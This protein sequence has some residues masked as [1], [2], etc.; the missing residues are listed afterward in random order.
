MTELVKSTFLCAQAEDQALLYAIVFIES[1]AMALD[2]LLSYHVM[3]K[4]HAVPP[5]DATHTIADF[6]IVW[7]F[8]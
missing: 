7:S 4:L 6:A 8:I 5:P 2:H 1:I 3:S